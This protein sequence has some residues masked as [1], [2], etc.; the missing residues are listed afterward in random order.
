LRDGHDVAVVRE[1]L[2]HAHEDDVRD[3]DGRDLA[4][5]KH[6]L[7]ED[8]RNAEVAVE[9]LAPGRAERAVERAAGLRGDAERR[10]ARLRNEDRLDGLTRADVEE[11]LAG[12]VRRAL[13]TQ[14]VGR[15]DLGD[16]LEP[17]AELDGTAGHRGK[18]RDAA[19]IDPAHDLAGAIRLLAERDEELGETFRR[20]AEEVGPRL[21]DG[22]DR[23]RVRGQMSA[24]AKKKRISA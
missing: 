4:P 7:A 11:P 24:S 5:R 1:R 13:V 19:L 3:L 10:A 23:Q 14:H 2:A 16:S 17:L 22:L 9:A 21:V 15:R 8:L 20:Q 18:V 6:D 12:A